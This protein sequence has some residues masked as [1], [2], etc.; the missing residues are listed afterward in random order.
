MLYTLPLEKYIQ[1]FLLVEELLGKFVSTSY[2]RKKGE[3]G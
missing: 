3:C 1:A 2:L